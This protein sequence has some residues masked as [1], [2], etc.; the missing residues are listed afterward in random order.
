MKVTHIE[1]TIAFNETE[2]ITIRAEVREDDTFEG[3]VC[4]LENRLDEAMVR[5]IEIRKEKREKGSDLV[6]PGGDVEVIR[7]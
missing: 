1:R 3:V 7:P 5:I 2:T 4:G 6:I